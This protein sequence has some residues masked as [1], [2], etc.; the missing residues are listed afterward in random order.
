MLT[1]FWNLAKIVL[2][3]GMCSL[4]ENVSCAVEEMQVLLFWA[5]SFI[6][7]LGPFGLLQ[8]SSPLS[9]KWFC[10]VDRYTI[11]SEILK[12]P[13]IIFTV[14][15]FLRFCQCFPN[16]FQCSAHIF[17]VVSFG[18]LTILKKLCYV[19]CFLMRVFNLQVFIFSYYLPSFGYH[20]HSMCFL[21]FTFSLCV[22]VLVSVE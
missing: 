12:C 4:L 10:Q 14:C 19:L 5:A 7:L 18:E 20:L 8:C 2:W 11:E 13:A 17:L 21:C 22:C 9:P 16:L 3:H 1:I 6:W 15:F